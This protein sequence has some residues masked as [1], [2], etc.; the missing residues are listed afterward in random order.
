MT[1]CGDG[2]EV[3]KE[4]PRAIDVM[5]ISSTKRPHKPERGAP[6]KKDLIPQFLV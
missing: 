2:G 4:S 6:H 5:A 3:P 1:I